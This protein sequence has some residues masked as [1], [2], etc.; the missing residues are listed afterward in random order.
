MPVQ[1]QLP[2]GCTVQGFKSGKWFFTKLCSNHKE[3]YY[4]NPKKMVEELGEKLKKKSRMYERTKTWNSAL[5]CT[6]QCI[7]C[8][9]SF[10]ETV[11]R[12]TM[13]S[14]SNCSFCLNYV[15]HEHPERLNKIPSAPIIFVFGDG[16]ITHYRPEFV[17]Q[18]IARIKEHVKRCPCKLFY[19][20]SK[21]P[22]C[23]Q[24]Y[25]EDLHSI[26]KN[27]ILLTTLETNRDV[28]YKK[29]SKAPPPSKRFKDFQTLNWKRKIVTI[30]PVMDFDLDAFLEWIKQIRPEAVYLGYNSRPEKVSLPEPPKEKFWKLKEQVEQ[31]GIEVKLKNTDRLARK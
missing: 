12:F 20:Q 11:A 25:L 5:G 2:C 28:G 3:P 9:P 23:L 22:A 4:A 8:K 31:L 18:V 27:V 30:E 6:Y 13:L 17:R 19:F 16:D 10:Q 15:P 26:E 1:K 24:Q 29:I 21:N 14:G 7:Y